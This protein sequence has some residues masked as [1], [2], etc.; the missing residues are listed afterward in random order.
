MIGGFVFFR[1]GDRF[2][3]RTCCI[4]RFIVSNDLVGVAS[5]RMGEGG[6]SGGF[7]DQG[8]FFYFFIYFL[9]V[10]AT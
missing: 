6:I 9:T 1:T 10:F 3:G 8:Y 4:F 5:E 2:E 7:S